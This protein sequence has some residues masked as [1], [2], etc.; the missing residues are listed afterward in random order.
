VVLEVQDPQAQLDVLRIEVQQLRA[1]LATAR[2]E[3]ARER[4]QH[5]QLLELGRELVYEV[6]RLRKQL[7]GRRSERRPLP[8]APPLPNSL[9]R[10]LS[11]EM[12]TLLGLVQPSTLG[13]PDPAATPVR[14]PSNTPAEASSSSEQASSDRKSS[15]PKKSTLRYRPPGSGRR[16]LPA[17]LR[18]RTTVL[19]PEAN[20]LSCPCCQRALRQIDEEVT[21]RLDWEPASLVRV[22]IVR[23]QFACSHC[24]GAGIVSAE[25][26]TAPLEGCYAEAGLLANVIVCKFCDGLPLYRQERIAV[27]HGFTLSRATMSR[28]IQ[29]VAALLRPLVQK[30][31]WPALLTQPMLHTDAT[32]LPVMQ[33][34]QVHRGHAFVYLAPG[35]LCVF[36]YNARHTSDAVKEHLKGYTGRLVCDAATIYDALFTTPGGPTE[37]ACWSHARHYV[38]E[39]T[40]TEP[41]IAEEGLAHIEQI[42]EAHRVTAAL[43]MPERTQARAERARPALQA[44]QDWMQKYQARAAPK[45]LLGAAMT[46]L[47]NQWTALT[48]FLEDGDLPLTNNASERELRRSIALG[49][50]NWLWVGNDLRADDAMVLLSLLGTCLARGIEPWSYLRWVLER[51]GGWDHR[52][53]KDLT[54]ESFQKMQQKPAE[55]GFS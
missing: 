10:L 41:A 18:E 7:Y 12:W 47:R 8:S 24:K 52:H 26:P 4:V 48:R 37:V 40:W 42:F 38:V 35:K 14:T 15:D 31:L 22:R 2:A 46:Y 9:Q 17:S 32:G 34:S 11:P 45:T 1:E 30:V 13:A 36:R 23:P 49:R 3:Q 43:P 16:K 44:L 29:G 39:A 51:I 5:T 25:A 33:S 50:K 27:R 20:E 28:W 54:P 55:S 53:L 19:W 21:E 6:L